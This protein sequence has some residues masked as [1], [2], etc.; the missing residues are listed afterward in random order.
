MAGEAL[1]NGAIVEV[2]VSTTETPSWKAVGGVQSIR[3]PSPETAEID[4]TALDSL[5]EETIPGMTAYG[6][7]SFTLFLRGSGGATYGSNQSELATLAA[8]KRVANF[9]ITPPAALTSSTITCMGWVKAFVED[10]TSKEAAKADVT[11]RWTGV[12]TRS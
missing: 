1:S 10:L 8:S 6:E 11:I 2:D 9:R 5:G 12:P 7:T 4:V 3:L